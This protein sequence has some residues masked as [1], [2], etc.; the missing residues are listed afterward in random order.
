LILMSLLFIRFSGKANP[1]LK[2]FHFDA[3]CVS[4]CRLPVRMNTPAAG[5]FHQALAISFMATISGAPPNN[6]LFLPKNSVK[7]GVEE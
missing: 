1:G 2:P 6:A 3:G 5:I 7:C 4:N